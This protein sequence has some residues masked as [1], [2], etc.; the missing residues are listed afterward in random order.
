VD[1]VCVPEV[2][3]MVIV[4]CPVGAELLATRVSMLDVPLLV[5]G[6]GENDAVTPSGKPEAERVTLPLNPY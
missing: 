2:P 4:Y 1:A 3:V 6:L 5:T